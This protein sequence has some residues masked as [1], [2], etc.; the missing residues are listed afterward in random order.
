MYITL[1]E[2]F[3]FCMLIIALIVLITDMNDHNKR[4]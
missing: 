2:L 3:D 4:K 1:E